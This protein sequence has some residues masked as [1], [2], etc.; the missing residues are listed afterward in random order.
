LVTYVAESARLAE[1]LN[2]RLRGVGAELAA[3][4]GRAA[5]VP[6]R[7]R[8]GVPRNVRS[9]ASAGSRITP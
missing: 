6:D 5:N 9:A 4:T 3:A 7:A 1:Q 8:N 2:R